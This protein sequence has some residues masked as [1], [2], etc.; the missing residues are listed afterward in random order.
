MIGNDRQPAAG[1]ECISEGRK[2]ALQSVQFIVHGDTDGLKEPGKVGRPRLGPERC[3]YGIYEIIAGGKRVSRS[4]AHYL[5][6]KAARAPLVSI[7][8]KDGLERFGVG[9]IEKIRS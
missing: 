7:V 5:R 2:C 4:P 9:V 3:P 6:C 8:P 1:L